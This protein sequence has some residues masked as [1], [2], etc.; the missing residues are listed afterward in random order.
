MTRT[1]EQYFLICP[2][3][4]S[5]SFLPRSSSHFF[6]AFVKAFFLDFDLYGR[7][8]RRARKRGKEGKKNM[9]SKK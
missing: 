4:F 7:G 1:T 3:S 6:E 8:E 9:I 2:R 5:I